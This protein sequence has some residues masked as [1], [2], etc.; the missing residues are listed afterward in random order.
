MIAKNI[1]FVSTR[2]SGTDGV[3]LE[4]SKWAE[5]MKKNGHCC[6]WFAGE[7]EREA[8]KSFLVPEAHFQH[9]QNRWINERIFGKEGREPAVTKLIHDLR[10]YLKAQL[11]NFIGQFKIDL[12][13]AENALTIPI[14]IP[15]GL[16]IV[17]TI[18]E[19][20][21]PTIAHHHDFYWERIRFSI[22]AVNDY[23][24]MAFPPNL[25]HIEHVVIN[26]AARE[27]L[28]HRRGISSTTIPNVLD[29]ENPPIIDT[30]RSE[31]FRE[32][33][34]LKKDDI[35]ILQPTR[36][37]KRKGIEYAIGLVKALE[38]PRY[39]LVISHEAGDEGFEYLEWVQEHA[40]DQGVDL[41]LV[42]TRIS[43]PWS[44]NINNKNHYSLWDIYPHAD[45]IT[46]PS[47]IEGFGNAF[48]EAVY[49]KKPIL[50]NRY[51]TFVRDIEPLGFD[52][53]VMDGFLTRKTVQKV[54]KILES[55]EKREKLV[56]KNYEIAARHY[57]YSVLKKR[58][59]SIMVNYFGEYVPQ[60]MQKVVSYF[61]KRLM[62]DGS[63]I[64]V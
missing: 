47:I 29:F 62:S 19:T 57:S 56:N 23:I 9:E 48:L 46:Y 34:G 61:T 3:T 26:S 13:I 50:I 52:L 28:A 16:A 36:V 39:K 63:S 43:D 2:F 35:I 64:Q 55:P 17:E 51:D 27:E 59:N 32:S 58:L 6:F 60:H 53:A 8:K 20:Q 10:S 21:I 22:N 54:R 49:F 5:I 25:P 38:D 15:L 14:Q 33:M 31:G 1:G 41:R 12:L 30:K 18:A 37:I 44:D 24:S 45:F 7:L 42:K 40:C 11:Y 4:S